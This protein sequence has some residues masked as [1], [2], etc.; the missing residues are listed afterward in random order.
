VDINRMAFGKVNMETGCRNLQR[1]WGSDEMITYIAKIYA[2]SRGF[3]EDECV[4]LTLKYHRRFWKKY[5]KKHNGF[6]PYIEA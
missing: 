2:N 1:L 4:R 6:K 5:S 3:N